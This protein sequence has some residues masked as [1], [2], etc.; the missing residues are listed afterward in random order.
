MLINVKGHNYRTSLLN[1]NWRNIELS[2]K[3]NH[4]IEFALL[5]N[6][7]MVN[8]NIFRFKKQKHRDILTFP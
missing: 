2:N 1:A 5:I 8:V 7:A 6:I 3:G 4:N